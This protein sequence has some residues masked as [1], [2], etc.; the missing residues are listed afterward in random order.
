MLKRLRLA[1]WS[2]DELFLATVSCGALAWALGTLLHPA[3]AVLPA[4]PWLIVVYFFR[5]PE[6]RRPAEPGL[7]LAPAD[8]TVMDIEE[9]YEPR[10]FDGRAL[11]IGI[12]LSPLNVHVNRM[13]CAGVVAYLRYAAG[14]FLPAY[15]PAA[16]TR[17]EAMELGL[18]STEGL[19]VLVKQIT[20][21]LA[22]RI[23]CD[24]RIGQVY[25]SGQRYGMI[26]FGSRT[27]LYVPAGAPYRVQVK[28]GDKVRGGDTVLL[29]QEAPVFTV[30][31]AGADADWS[32]PLVF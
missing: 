31:V 29:R 14:E 6:R 16:P 3:L 30:E 25:A 5:D 28:V 32:R 11:R 1:E 24:A 21:V 8:G 9:L 19:P 12:F 20:G 27:E 4:L 18:L 23:V 15:N 10:F 17:N 26:K 13:P 22:R 2:G 7:L